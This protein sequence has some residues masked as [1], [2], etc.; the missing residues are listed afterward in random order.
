MQLFPQDFGDDLL[1]KVKDFSWSQWQYFGIFARQRRCNRPLNRK[2]YS[3]MAYRR[4][5]LGMKKCHMTTFYHAMLVQ[6]K[7]SS[8][9]CLQMWSNMYS[10][11][12]CH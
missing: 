4:I 8:C 6:Y 7:Q 5:I 1:S 9:V 2:W 12:W 3:Y 11:F 10:S